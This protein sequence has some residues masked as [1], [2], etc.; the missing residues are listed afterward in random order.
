MSNKVITRFAPSPTGLLHAGNYRTALFAYIYALQNKGKY[1]LRI[2]D[3][4]KNRSKKEYEDNIAESLKWL[5]IKHHEFFRQSDR[6]E[7]YKKYIKRLIDLGHAYVSKEIPK[8]EGD[9]TEVIRFKNPNKKI[10]FDD[11]IRG[12]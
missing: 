6:T 9:R 8:E 2:E 1:I 3:S 10:V 4:D 11:I 5:G 12:K 7:I